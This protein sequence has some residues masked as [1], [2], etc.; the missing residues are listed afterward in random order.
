MVETKEENPLVVR[1]TVD[2]E[3][4]LHGIRAHLLPT[5]SFGVIVH[6]V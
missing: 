2:G 5:E 6:V 3:L 4:S 1:R